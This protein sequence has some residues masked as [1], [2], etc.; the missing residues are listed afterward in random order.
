MIISSF[1]RPTV[2]NWRLTDFKGRQKPKIP[3]PS[4]YFSIFEWYHLQLYQKVIWN[5]VIWQKWC[6]GQF[7]YS[8]VTGSFTHSPRLY[9]KIQLNDLY[10]W[11][12]I[13]VKLQSF[14]V[15]LPSI[16]YEGTLCH[17]Y[18][19][20]FRN[21]SKVSLHE[22]HTMESNINIEPEPK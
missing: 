4:V 17:T 1:R 22:I 3:H 16:V 15:V 5:L 19:L 18:H 14:V 12:H 11:H 2:L 21:N 8:V 13:T 9:S 10:L 20:Y 7:Y 6:F